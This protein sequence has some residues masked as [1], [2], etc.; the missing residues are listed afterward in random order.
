MEIRFFFL[1]FFGFGGKGLEEKGRGAQGEWVGMVFFV[2]ASECELESS[3]DFKHTL[4]VCERELTDALRSSA[5]RRGRRMQ[6][7]AQQ[8][9]AERRSRGKRAWGAKDASARAPV[10]SPASPERRTNPGRDFDILDDPYRKPKGKKKSPNRTAHPAA[11]TYAELSVSERRLGNEAIKVICDRG[12]THNRLLEKARAS[13]D[14]SEPKSR[15][16]M[17]AHK[18]KLRDP[19]PDLDLPKEVKMHSSWN[20]L[21]EYKL[22]Q[23]FHKLLLSRTK[24][25]LDTN[26][27]KH[28]LVYQKR[29]RQELKKIL[30][31]KHPSN[32]KK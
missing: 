4:D 25:N 23:H 7:S 3:T 19:M 21:T 31:S 27:P 14:T 17:R 11:T 8:G 2:Y 18:S 29:K 10:R 13:I 16:L 15:Q 30:D 26:L 1:I 22:G 28:V 12:K 24:S 6:P 9:R 20:E 32:K 5:G